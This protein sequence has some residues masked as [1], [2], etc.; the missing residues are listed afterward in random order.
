MAYDPAGGLTDVD[1]PGSGSAKQAALLLLDE[2][3]VALQPSPESTV[4]IGEQVLPGVA[5]SWSQVDAVLADLATRYRTMW[6][7][8]YVESVEALRSDAV[9][10]LVSL[11]LAAPTTEG[12]AV[13][14]FAARYQPQ[15]T[16]RAA[17]QGSLFEGLPR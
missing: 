15:V 7:N 6:K 3:V 16:T 12:L 8:A 14:P 9:D 11:R 13:F 2:L 10:V 1:F 4:T 5:A 17:A